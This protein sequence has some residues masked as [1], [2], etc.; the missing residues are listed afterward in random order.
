MVVAVV[1][2]VNSKSERAMQ[3]KVCRDARF[4]IGILH[5]RRR[6]RRNRCLLANVEQSLQSLGDRTIW[7]G[8]E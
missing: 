5:R 7:R 6:R 8:V 1:L 3:N 2:R 4:M